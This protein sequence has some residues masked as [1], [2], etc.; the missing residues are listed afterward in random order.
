MG[1]RHGPA[2]DPEGQ[3][4]GRTTSDSGCRGHPR[5]LREIRPKAAGLADPVSRLAGK[6]LSN[7]VRAA[8]RAAGLGG[9]LHSDRTG[10]ARQIVAAGAP[11]QQYSAMAGGSTE[12]WWPFTHEVKRLGKH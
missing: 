12:T 10:M 6:A 5:A 1:R 7:R 4:P 3:D 2:D 8:A 11:T 9:R